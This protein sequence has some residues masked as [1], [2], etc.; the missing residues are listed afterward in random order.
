[1]RTSYYVSLFS[2]ITALMMVIPSY[3]QET[4]YIKKCGNT[5]SD[6]VYKEISKDSLE[7]TVGTQK[8][9]HGFDQKHHNTS[10]KISDPSCNMNVT[11]TLKN[12]LYHI[13][14]TSEG[15][16]IDKT[17]KS[18]GSPWVQNLAFF[19]GII[20]PEDGTLEYECFRPGSFTLNQMTAKIEKGESS[21]TRTCVR[22][23]PTGLAAKLFHA[24]YFFSPKSRKLN[25]YKAVEG[26]PGTPVT[27]WTPA[28]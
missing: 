21:S 12:G 1:M 18:G 11:I 22:A 5:V 28:E 4:H 14:G 25:G 16:K 8:S 7:I 26:G 27:T 20:V 13:I 10:W 24:D 15:K 23:R 3:G 19:C 9:I 6:V 2:I 17:V